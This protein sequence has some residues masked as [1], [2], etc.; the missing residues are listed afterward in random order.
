MNPIAKAPRGTA[1]V[2][3]TEC[4]KL[5]FLEEKFRYTAERFGYREIRTPVFEHTELFDR[6][7]GETTDVVQKEMYTFSDKGGR[8]I[9]LRPEGTAGVA[10][11][12]IEHGLCGDTMPKK[13]YYNTSCYR[14]EK[15]QAGR[16]REF[17][18]LGVEC[19]GSAQAK[20]DA[21]VIALADS[22]LRAAGAQDLRLTI[23]S[24]GCPNCRAAYYRALRAYFEE[25]KGD[26]CETCL[27]RLEKNPMRILDCK[28]PVCSAAAADAP[29]ILDYLCPDCKAHFEQVRRYLEALHIDYT[30]DPRVVRGLDYYTRTVFEFISDQIGAQGTVCAGGRYDGLVRELGGGD[31]PAL[32]FG[33]GVERLK[34]LLEA[35]DAIPTL[36]EDCDIYL[37]SADPEAEETVFV[38]ANELRKCSVHARI[39]LCGRSVKAQMKHANKLGAVYTVVIGASE[40]KSG[41][42]TL[43]HMMS[44]ETREMKLADFVDDFADLIDEFIAEAILGD[45]EDDDFDDDD[46][47]MPGDGDPSNGGLTMLRGGKNDE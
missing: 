46:S 21:E 34:L 3:P 9:T 43:K 5:H 44:G 15:P 37:I 28:S 19:F 47:D 4:E 22:F 42:L 25:K 20:A 30:I 7:V 11:A 39:D 31:L 1:D 35:A 36:E 23:N 45:W 2:L 12:L 29:V 13:F 14:Y 27:G 33:I 10:R 41:K 18:Q 8:S 40:L 26:L 38:L 32:G 24:I 16:L 17:H 6:S